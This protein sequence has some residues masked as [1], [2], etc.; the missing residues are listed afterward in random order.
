M[1]ICVETVIHC[2]NY[3]VV[4]HSQMLK[5]CFLCAVIHLSK[6]LRPHISNITHHG[7]E[8][9]SQ[10]TLCIGDAEHINKSTVCYAIRK[11]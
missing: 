5:H 4:S 9:V 7:C 2:P 11:G 1:V 10:L 3:P 6:I 8:L